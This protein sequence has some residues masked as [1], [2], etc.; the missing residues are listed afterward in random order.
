M[1]EALVADPRNDDHAIIS[2]LTAMFALLHNGLID[3]RHLPDELQP[4][5]GS[6]PTDT[7]PSTTPLEQSEADA[8][9]LTLSRNQGNRDATAAELGISRTTLWRKMKKHRLT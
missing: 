5:E 6:P 1:T 7:K 2:Q 9:R 8:I 4:V 3:V